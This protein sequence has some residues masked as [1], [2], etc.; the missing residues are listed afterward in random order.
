MKRVL[1]LEPYFGGSH[2]A[3]LEGLQQAVSAEFTLLTLPARKWKMRM[4][5]SAYWFAQEIEKYAVR[6]RSFDT[7]L[8]STF[9]DVA[10][11][12]SLLAQIAGW[13]QHAKVITYFHENQFAYPA[14]KNAPDIRQFSALNLSTAMASDLCIFNSKYNM[15]SFLGAIQSFLKKASDMKPLNSVEVLRE[16]SIILYPGMDYS[17]IDD[18]E[19]RSRKKMTDVTTIVWNHR[20]EH[21]KGPELFFEALYIIQEKRIPFHLIVLGQSFGDR[22]GCFYEASVRL[23]EEIVHFGYVETS[24]EYAQLLHRGD[25][26]VSTARHEFFGISVVEGIRAGCYP[27]LPNDLSYPE[28]YQEEFL[29]E[30][31]RLAGKLHD[32][33]LQPATL[34]WE[35]IKKIT[36]PFAW[37]CCGRQYEECLLEPRME[38]V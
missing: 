25:V 12:R 26:I 9:V 20:W 2:K 31:G 19:E 34:S 4:Q 33:L 5:L 13:N 22:P 23:S 17:G 3:F 21:D 30:P 32:F 14:Q 8:C 11:L 29:Y 24:S 38:K 7:V 28:L 6:Q 27:L 1:I 18:V 15:E 35:D 36:E 10:A 16:K 37:V